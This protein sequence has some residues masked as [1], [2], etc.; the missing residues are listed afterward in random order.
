[1]Y[2]PVGLHV[3]YVESVEISHLYNNTSNPYIQLIYTV[4]CYDYN[5]G[6]RI[7]EGG[8]NRIST[9]F[10]LTPCDNMQPCS[11]GHQ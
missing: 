3:T 4:H 6:V 8:Y 9:P 7:E 10:I 2:L 5:Q 11:Y 1:M